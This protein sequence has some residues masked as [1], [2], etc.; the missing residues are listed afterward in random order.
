MMASSSY[1]CVV[2]SDLNKLKTAQGAYKKMATPAAVTRAARQ[3]GEQLRQT[4]QKTI[5]G[6]GT[7]VSYADVAQAITVFEDEGNVVVGLPPGHQLLARACEMDKLYPV[8]EV[9]TDLAQQYGDIEAEFFDGLA[10]V[11]TK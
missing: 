5:L 4:M 8:A 6:E 10:E 1:N 7:L 3:A 11:V 9:V 2:A